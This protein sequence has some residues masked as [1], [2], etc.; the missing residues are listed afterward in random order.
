V[1]ETKEGIELDRAIAGVI[2]LGL[3]RR[4]LD[5]YIEWYVD[6]L[7]G[8]IRQ[9]KP[10]V[11]LKDAFYAAEKAGLFIGCSHILG[12]GSVSEPNG[13]W[14]VHHT[15]DRDDELAEESEIGSGATPALA[16]CAAILK[17]VK[18]DSINV[19]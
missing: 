5:S 4:V 17:T 19:V 8:A 1:I 7:D 18:I 13:H 10:S 12:R 9:F 2:G 14:W 15:R 11:D 6:P 16:I 3:P